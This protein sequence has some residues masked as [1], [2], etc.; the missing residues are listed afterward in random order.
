MDLAKNLKKISIMQPC[1]LPWCGYF[2][3]IIKSNIFVFLTNVKLEK[4]SWQ[5][6]NM[7]LAKKKNYLLMFQYQAQGCKIFMKLRYTID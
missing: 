6:K 4:N 2:Y 1:F 3:L 7:I 5:T